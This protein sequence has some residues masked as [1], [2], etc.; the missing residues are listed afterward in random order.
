MS[1]AETDTPQ[2]T[3]LRDN[4]RRAEENRRRLQDAGFKTCTHNGML[5]CCVRGVA[6]EGGQIVVDCKRHDRNVSQ[7]EADRCP[8]PRLEPVVAV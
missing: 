4:I 8:R 6:H 5:C 3:D 7:A 1:L 2:E